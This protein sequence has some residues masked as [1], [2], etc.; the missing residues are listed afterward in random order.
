MHE[1]IRNQYFSVHKRVLQ[2]AGENVLILKV[3]TQNKF[4]SYTV[5]TPPTE[6]QGIIDVYI[7]TFK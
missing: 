1:S 2:L 3:G 4:H 6:V 7:I 5:G